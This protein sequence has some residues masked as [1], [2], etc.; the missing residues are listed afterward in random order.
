MNSALAHTPNRNANFSLREASFSLRYN[1]LGYARIRHPGQQRPRAPL[2]YTR[3]TVTQTSVC[4]RQAK[5]CATIGWGMREFAILDNN[6]HEL[7][8]G[9]HA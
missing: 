9:T 4:E 6:G 2:W 8:F 7:R 5:A 1:W 3:L